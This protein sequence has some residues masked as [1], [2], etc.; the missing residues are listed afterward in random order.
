MGRTVTILVIVAIIIVAGAVLY[1]TSEAKP[2]SEPRMTKKENSDWQRLWDLRLAELRKDFGPENDHVLTAMP[3]F[4]LGGAADVLTFQKKLPGVT[5]VTAAIIG[6]N[7]AKPNSL[8]Q[9]ELMICQRKDAT[10]APKLISQLARYTTQD[11]LSPNDTMEIGP[12]LPQPTELSSLL[13]L[14]YVK[15]NVNGKDA[16]VMLCIG[17]TPDELEFIQKH[18]VEDL[19]SKLKSA[20]VYPFT[21]LD[22]KSVLKK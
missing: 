2:P 16:A 14:P 5:Y 3:P 11:I 20:G 15:L 18:D 9:Y 17:I 19:V 22:R 12:S 21:D 13:F 7:Q 8:G 4:Y 10:W 1:W 6:D